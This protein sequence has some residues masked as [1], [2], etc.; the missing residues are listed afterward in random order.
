[1]KRIFCIMFATLLSATSACTQDDEAN[2]KAE[3][4]KAAKN[5]P[6]LAVAMKEA[7]VSLEKG[8]EASEKEGKPISAKF[9][10]QVEDEN[11]DKDEDEGGKL[12]LSVYT[13]KGDKF[14]EV[15]IDH[16]SGMIAKTEPITGGDDLADAKKQAEAMS[17]AKRSLREVVTQAEKANPGYQAVSVV[18]EIEGD[19]LQ[20][21]LVLLK[22]SESK[23]VEEKL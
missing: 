12:Q 11:E 9:E 5:A 20:A 3:T 13:A 10:V 7:K 6:A 18:P 19:G 21:D 8:L 16:K 4:A 1:M 23:Q 22:G 15:V 2:Q 14:F 17:K